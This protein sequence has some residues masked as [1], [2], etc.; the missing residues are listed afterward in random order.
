MM[1]VMWCLL[2]LTSGKKRPV[3]DGVLFSEKDSSK[4][5]GVSASVMYGIREEDRDRLVILIADGLTTDEALE[6]IALTVSDRT[7]K[8]VRESRRVADNENPFR[9][10]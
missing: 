8:I 9:P 1:L 4:V 2:L 5:R 7:G 3:A 6:V 10:S